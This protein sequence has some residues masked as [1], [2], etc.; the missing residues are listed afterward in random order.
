MGT[1]AADGVGDVFGGGELGVFGARD[2]PDRLVGDKDFA[3]VFGGDFGEAADELVV[4]DEV[5]FAKVAF[6][7]SF[8]DAEDGGDVV[9]EGGGDFLADVA[10][11]FAE[12]VATLGMADEGVVYDAAELVG[13]SFAG[14]GTEVAV[15]EVLG[16]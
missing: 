5:G 16:G 6:V 12:D 11:G 13:G 10:V 9:P 2:G 4:E 15:V 8:A 1:D 14:K 7:G 3:D